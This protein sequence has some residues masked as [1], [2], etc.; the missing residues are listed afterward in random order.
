VL[1]RAAIAAIAAAA[2]ASVLVATA[3]L[4]L[5]RQG[6]TNSE[7][8]LDLGYAARFLGIVLLPLVVIAQVGDRVIALSLALFTA[9]MFLPVL[10]RHSSG[11]ALVGVLYWTNVVLVVALASVVVRATFGRACHLDNTAAAS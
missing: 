7:L 4:V 8:L 11:L 9:S 2:V 3:L 10:Q 6:A 1:R 5:G